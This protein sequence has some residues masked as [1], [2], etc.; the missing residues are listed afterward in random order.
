MWRFGDKSGRAVAARAMLSEEATA[1]AIAEYE[2][3]TGRKVS[4]GGWYN[5]CHFCDRP[6]RRP[7][8][9]DCPQDCIMS[10][11]RADEERL[12]W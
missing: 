6:D 11:S 2:A 8:R 7:Y 10:I 3:K 5:L 1:K 9:G 12:L 4:N